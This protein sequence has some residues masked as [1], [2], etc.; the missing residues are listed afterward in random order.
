MAVDF[1]ELTVQITLSI[2]ELRKLV[3]YINVAE[4]YLTGDGTVGP[5]PVV[6]E[7]SGLYF[8]L[9]QSLQEDGYLG[10]FAPEQ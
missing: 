10:E 4:E 3:E 9:M 8:R 2:A 5:E 6:E 7:V 1:S